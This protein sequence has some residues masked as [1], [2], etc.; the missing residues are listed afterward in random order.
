MLTRREDGYEID[1]TAERLDVDLV[2]RWLTTDA[3]WAVGRSADV[4]ARSIA[5]SLC[6]GVYAP[7]GEQVAVARVV[8]DEATF[9]WLCDVY[10]DR[11]SRGLGLGTW[12]SR[13]AVADLRDRGVPRLV[14]ATMDAHTVYQQAGFVP[15]ANPGRWMEIDLRAP[16]GT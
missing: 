7:T 8:T 14:L 12:L 2:T 4:I 10:V 16:F 3:Y 6:F 1:T 11:G 15:L 13:T 9:A 5:N